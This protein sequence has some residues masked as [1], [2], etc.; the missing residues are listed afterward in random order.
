MVYLVG[1]CGSQASDNR[2]HV[3]IDT[4]SC[5]ADSMSEVR[6]PPVL[7]C[8]IFL[9]CFALCCFCFCFHFPGTGRVR[10][11]PKVTLNECIPVKRDM[12]DRLVTRCCEILTLG[13]VEENLKCVSICEKR[14]VYEGL[15]GLS[16]PI[17]VKR[18]NFVI[19]G[20]SGLVK[21]LTTVR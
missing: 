17:Y 14:M 7:A 21:W 10:V 2:H 9:V 20:I 5:R 8:F 4:I 16:E 18:E 12:A 13:R 15:R 3:K 19:H 11:G 6:S 1:W